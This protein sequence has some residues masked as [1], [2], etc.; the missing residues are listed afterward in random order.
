MIVLISIP[1]QRPPDWQIYQDEDQLTDESYLPSVHYGMDAPTTADE[2]AKVLAA[3]WHSYILVHNEEEARALAQ[4]D[5]HGKHAVR[6]FA[7]EI[8]EEFRWRREDTE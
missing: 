5:G 3:D 8:E 1:H 4:Y 6:A 2:A 7:E